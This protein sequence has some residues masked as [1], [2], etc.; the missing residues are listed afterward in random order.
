MSV[1]T[2][3]DCG[4]RYRPTVGHC[5]G[6]V[7]DG[8]CSSFGDMLSADRHRVGSLSDGTRRCLTVAERLG[9]GWVQD[10]HGVWS[11]PRAAAAAAR[12]RGGCGIQQGA[13]EAP[14]LGPGANLAGEAA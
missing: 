8:C 4:S 13:T 5:R 9:A 14:N 11:H 10:E 3:G 1:L 6:G 2:C 12:V 7:Y